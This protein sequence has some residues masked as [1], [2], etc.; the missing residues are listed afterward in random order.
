MSAR[1]QLEQIGIRMTPVREL[2]YKELARSEVAMSLAD[3]ETELETVDKS[4]ISRNLHLF[5]EAGIIHQID[6]GS[7]V[8][9][10]AITHFPPDL[11]PETHAH[12]TCRKCGETI[13]LDAHPIPQYPLPEG[14]KSEG[15]SL[16]LKGVCAHC[17]RIE[18][19]K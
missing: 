12:F 18:E 16:V 15:Y 7:R 4:S 1:R 17:S 10:Y 6:D 19:E 13:C 14:F 3:L 9:K 8:S 2:I 5:L 11:L